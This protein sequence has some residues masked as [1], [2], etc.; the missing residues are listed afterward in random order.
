MAVPQFS[1]DLPARTRYAVR[2]TVARRVA[3]V[4][5]VRERGGGGERGNYAVEWDRNKWWA[6][7]SSFRDVTAGDYSYTRPCGSSCYRHRAGGINQR[8]V[9]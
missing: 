2:E 1:A 8:D 9:A 5:P 7:L 6:S 4:L 3:P